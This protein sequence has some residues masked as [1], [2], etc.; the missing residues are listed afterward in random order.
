MFKNVIMG[1]SCKKR[2]IAYWIGFYDCSM[3]KD[4]SI[5]FCR[6]FFDAP[7][8]ICFVMKDKRDKKINTK[9]TMLCQS[10]RNSNVQPPTALFGNTP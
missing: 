9:F 5:M 1:V 10:S 8:N 3:I 6:A 4:D 7:K 2:V